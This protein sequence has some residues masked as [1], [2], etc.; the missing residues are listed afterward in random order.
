[1]QL[2]LTKRLSQSFT[3]QASYTWSRALGES[4]GDNVID[5]VDPRNRSRNKAPLGFHRTQFFTAN[6]TFELPFGPNRRFLNGGPGLV[7]R[8]VERW[9]FGGIFSRTSGAPLTITAPI[10]TVWQIATNNTP[11]IVGN[12]PKSS[13][14]VTKVG[15]GVIYFPGIQQ[16][17][18]PSVANVTSLNGLNGGF[19]NKAIA[20]SEGQLLLVNPVP[21]QAGNLGQKWIQGPPLVSFDM[22]V[23]KRLSITE[24]KQFE[25]R[26]DV[27]NL[28]NHPNFGNPV[29]NINNLSFGHIT[30]AAGNRRFVMNARVNF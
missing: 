25:F 22:N 3:T 14:Q 16:I 6:G 4:D 18:D 27:I 13:G 10:S 30:T 11:N 12:F 24:T 5:Y 21:G 17:P 29:A 26:M 15:N 19:S 7:Q 28:L 8:L 20:N 9:Q 2:Q 1:M 23:I